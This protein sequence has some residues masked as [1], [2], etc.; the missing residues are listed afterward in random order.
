MKK[1]FELMMEPIDGDTLKGS[2][3][4]RTIVESFAEKRHIYK[5]I[6]IRGSGTWLGDEPLPQ[7]FPDGGFSQRLDLVAERT[8]KYRLHMKQFGGF[9]D[10]GFN[11]VLFNQI[12][13]AIPKNVQLIGYVNEIHDKV[14]MVVK[15]TSD[16]SF[17][18][19][20]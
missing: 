6:E 5:S 7:K 1:K 8:H 14:L 15:G 3:V 9:F 20:V 11:K 10:K 2:E 18:I 17:E 16:Q 19:D 4:L 13:T 12:I